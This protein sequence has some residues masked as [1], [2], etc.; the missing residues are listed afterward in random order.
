MA[1]LATVETLAFKFGL[2]SEFVGAIL[3]VFSNALMVSVVGGIDTEFA[4]H[5]ASNQV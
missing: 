4:I 2:F 1:V 3:L 5:D